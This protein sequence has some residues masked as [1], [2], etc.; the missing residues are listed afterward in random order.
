[1]L[2]NYLKLSLRL[3]ARNPF[4]TFINVA[5]LSVGFV[6]FIVLW[7][8]ATYELNSDQFH[9]DHKKIYRSY[10]D[11][12]FEQGDVWDHYVYSTL[13]PILIQ[14]VAER[15]EDVESVTR[16]IHQKNFNAVRWRGP[17]TDTAGYSELSSDVVMS[18]YDQRG[19]KFS[20]S[21]TKSC[22][23]DP[24]FF[25]FFS[26]RLIKG[27]PQSVLNRADAIVLSESTARKYFGKSDPIGRT[28]TLNDKK[29]FTV[30]G[31]FKDI[32]HNSHL[33]MELLFSTLNIYRVME[34][35]DPFQETA[36]G[37]FKLREGADLKNL[38]LLFF[39]EFMLHWSWI[40]TK[41][42]PGSKAEFLFQALADASFH[43]LENDSYVPKSKF[44]LQL[45]LVVGFVVLIMA[46]INYLN[47]KIATQ[48]S[49]MKEI[50]T[51]KTAGARLPDFIKQFFV[52]SLLINIIAAA[53][54]ITLIQLLRMPLEVLFQ[55]Y[56]PD[57]S[58]LRIS[59]MLVFLAIM[60]VGVLIASLHPALAIFRT[61]VRS[62]LYFS[63]PR[64][65]RNV[66]I[67]VASVIQFIIGIVV[68]LLLATVNSQVS[69]VLRNSWGINRDRV[70]VVELPRHDSIPDV[71]LHLDKFKNELLALNGIEDVAVS[72]TAIGDL[73]RNRVGFSPMDESHTWI[74]PKSDGGVDERYIPFYGL[75]VLA[76]R[77]FIRGNPSDEHA[78]IISNKVASSLG[79]KPEEAIGKKVLVEKYSWRNIQS[80]A[81][82]IGVID[83]HRY[84]PLY[85]ETTISDANP[86]T[87]LTYGNNLFVNNQPLRL[88]IRLINVD[89]PISGIEKKFKDNFPGKIF[90]WYFLDDHMN[91]HYQSEQIARNQISL[92]SIV[93]VGI[94]CLGLLGMISN[95]SVAKTKEIGI[96]KVLGARLY[97]IGQI[98]LSTTVRQIGIAVMLGLPVAYILTNQYFEKF[99]ERVELQLWHFALPVMILVLIMLATVATVLYKAAKSNPVEALKYE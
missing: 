35:T 24:N 18:F 63:G 81:E 98:L 14:R 29:S 7:Q 53:V 87:L 17:Q 9:S 28:L 62:M 64:S 49:R 15:S 45:F 39:D 41:S 76:G 84:S 42:F 69:F 68:I 83:D 97:Q 32:G 22:F 4:F 86:G 82:I 58:E 89:S 48:A 50:A 88:S 46:W 47:L 19:D 11:F 8:H 66:F 99:A 1:M 27:E 73:I 94:A 60:G 38:E 37:Y 13:P 52:E 51:R 34:S 85:M 67:N 79:W 44:T 77:N 70:M 90:T 43:V 21:E 40:L 91:V 10:C 31:V 95:K 5:G 57:W 93:A 23:A 26:L 65:Q 12:F 3:L 20:F 96:R 78:I 61:S 55:F 25:Q 16:L 56:V 75:K 33:N 6:V 80:P 54:A 74:V 59:T 2:L 71:S 92:F 72:S 30:T 36:V